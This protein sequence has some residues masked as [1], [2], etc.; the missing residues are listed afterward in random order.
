MFLPYHIPLFAERLD[1]QHVSAGFRMNIEFPAL[2][3]AHFNII[4]TD[5][6]KKNFMESNCKSES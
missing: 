5:Y 4:D 2:D 3:G 1:P 6:S